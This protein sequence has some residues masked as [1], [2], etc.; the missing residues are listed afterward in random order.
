MSIWKALFG[1][2][3]PRKSNSSYPGEP[4]AGY[5]QPLTARNCNA[6]KVNGIGH[7][8]EKDFDNSKQFEIDPECG[9]CYNL[10]W[11]KFD[12]WY[13]E[14]IDILMSQGR[15]FF[16]VYTFNGHDEGAEVNYRICESREQMEEVRRS[17][18]D[19]TDRYI[20]HEL[21]LNVVGGKKI[22]SQPEWWADYE[23]SFYESEKLRQWQETGSKQYRL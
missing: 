23:S 15:S 18:D 22:D 10:D 16:V 13:N 7:V 9:D 12:D 1:K 17:Y 6:G 5:N 14:K 8:V 2:P 19:M 21:V 11:E 3:E 20:P 4:P